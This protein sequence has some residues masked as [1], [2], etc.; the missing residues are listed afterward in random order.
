MSSGFG[1]LLSVNVPSLETTEAGELP[2]CSM[3]IFVRA[4]TKI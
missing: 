3:A 2:L 4:Q 1:D